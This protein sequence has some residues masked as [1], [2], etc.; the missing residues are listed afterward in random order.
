MIILFIKTYMLHKTVCILEPL[1]CNYFKKLEID[2]LNPLVNL[3]S[4][5]WAHVF[6]SSFRRPTL[7][8]HLFVLSCSR[9]HNAL[10]IHFRCHVEELA[11]LA[12]VRG[13][14]VAR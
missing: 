8:F 2:L 13:A 14:T 1:N 12:A 7:V 4:V 3:L 10:L 6:Q 11:G 5:L 9:L